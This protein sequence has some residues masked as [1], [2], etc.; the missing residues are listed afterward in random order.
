MIYVVPAILILTIVFAMIK[1]VPVYDSFIDG[2][3]ESFALV[4]SLL[5]YLAGIFMLLE[6]L[7]ISGLS[8]KIS[9]VLGYPFRYIGIPKEL[10]ELLFLRPL[11][12]TGSLAVVEKIFAEHGVDSYVA[13]CASV[14][15]ASNDTVLYITA[16]YLSTSK[17]KTSGLA[18]PISIF[19]SLVGAVA[20]CLL[21]KVM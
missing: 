8:V 21:C 17:D 5:P 10:C 13:R 20:A 7:Q 3:K 19:A 12:G 4:V 2:A 16:V 18:I 15:M 11:S 14:I 1:K 6:V 9:A